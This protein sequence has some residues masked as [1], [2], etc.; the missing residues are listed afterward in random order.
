MLAYIGIFTDYLPNIGKGEI[1]LLVLHIAVV[2]DLEVG[3][4]VP[5]L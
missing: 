5:L 4:L 1:S 2:D 3:W